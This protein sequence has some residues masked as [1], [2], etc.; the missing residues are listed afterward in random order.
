MSDAAYV[1]NKRIKHL[2]NMIAADCP[3]EP[4]VP[5]MR[6][7]VKTIKSISKEYMY[8]IYQSNVIP[9]FGNDIQNKRPYFVTKD[10]ERALP[11]AVW[12]VPYLSELYSSLP[13]ERIE[14]YWV[15]LKKL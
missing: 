13:P 11:L 1:F 6:G 15:H 8:N 10:V 7:S 9:I 2:M 4:F 5:L 12:L 14:E 3:G